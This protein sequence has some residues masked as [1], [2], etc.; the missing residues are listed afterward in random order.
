[1]LLRALHPLTETPSLTLVGPQEYSRCREMNGVVGEGG[2]CAIQGTNSQAAT[3]THRTP[4][5]HRGGP[6]R[7]GPRRQWGRACWCCLAPHFGT[8]E[9]SVCFLITLQADL[10]LTST[11]LL[12]TLLL[13]RLGAVYQCGEAGPS[14]FQDLAHFHP[15][16]WPFLTGLLPSS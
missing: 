3:G 14:I 5:F 1:M 6:A 12:P 10:F 4:K 7:R 9:S 11:H 16:L 8:T 13:H 15:F 2:R